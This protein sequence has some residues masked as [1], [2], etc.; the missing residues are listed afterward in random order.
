MPRGTIAVEEA[1]I[2]PGSAWLLKEDLAKLSPGDFSDK[3]FE[4]HK[5]RLMDIH[6]KRLQ[7][8]DNE[9]VE[10]MLLSLTSPGCQGIP[11]QALAEATARET[12]DWL[13]GEVAKNP[14]RFGGLAALSMHDPFQAAE[15]LERAVKEL[16]FFGGLVNDFQSTGDRTGKEYFDT[17]KFDPFWKKVEELD[18]PI[19]F[20]PRYTTRP[21]LEAGTKYGDRSHLMGAAVQFHLDLSFHIYAMCSSGNIESIP[22]AFKG[23]YS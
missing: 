3:F 17:G 10:Y 5:A 16:G 12:N 19:Y 4:E 7:S 21:E 22:E 23:Y 15:E 8:M 18:V 14:V 2:S 1:V 11:E 20:H 9:G 6:N 13:A